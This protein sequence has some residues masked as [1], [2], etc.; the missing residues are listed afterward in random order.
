MTTIKSDI[1]KIFATKLVFKRKIKRFIV[2]FA[3]DKPQNNEK[4]VRL[5]KFYAAG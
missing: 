3:L 2:F 1:I 5:G 4:T